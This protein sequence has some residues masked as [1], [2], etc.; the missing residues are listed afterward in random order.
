MRRFMVVVPLVLALVAAACTSGGNTNTSG[1]P[2]AVA[3][4]SSRC[5]WATRLRRPR[6]NRSSSCRCRRSSNAYNASQSK[7]HVTMQYVNSDYALTKA[8]GGAAGRQAAGHLLPVRNEHAAARADTQGRRPHEPRERA[9]LQLER[10]LPGRAR[11]GN[12]GREGPRDPR[13]RGQPRRGLQQ[14]PVQAGGRPRAHSR[15]GRGT[16]SL[17][18]RRR[19]RTPPTTSSAWRSR[20]TGAR[21]PSGSTRPCCGRPAATSSTATT[22]RLRSTRREGVRALTTLQQMQQDNS[23]YLDFHPDSGKSENLFNSGNIGMM[24]TGPWD[25]SELP[26]RELRRA[27]HAVVRSG[28]QPHHDRGSRQLG[29]LRQR[30]GAGRRLVGLPQVPE[31]DPR[32]CSRIR[33][34]PGTCPRA[35]P[36]SRWRAFAAF[37]K[38]YPGA[39]TFAENLAN[40]Q[41]ARPQITQYP[42]DLGGARPGDRERPPG[43]GPAAAGA[44]RRRRRRRT[45]SWRLPRNARWRRGRGSGGRSGPTMWSGGPS[46]SPPSS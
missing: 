27:G 34:R 18:R 2:A 22:R 4:S 5:G 42:A 12:G 1:R 45:A 25:L 41:K 44:G 35:P 9:R 24:I 8:D 19:S 36:W 33:W 21:P 13:A 10:L 43:Q 28:R 15:T 14:G 7:V 31:L 6:P 3:R 30:S 32:S 46:R 40:V 17:P 16:T 38:K 37:D 23:L 29:D 26:G 20:R 11:R 39:G